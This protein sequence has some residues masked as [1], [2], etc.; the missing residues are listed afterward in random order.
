MTNLNQELAQVRARLKS[1]LWQVLNR[2]PT[3]YIHW[4]KFLINVLIRKEKEIIP[5]DQSFL[6]KFVVELEKEYATLLDYIEQEAKHGDIIELEK[7]VS[8]KVN[9]SFTRTIKDFL[10]EYVQNTEENIN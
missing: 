3:T 7:Y 6:T 10:W 4:R 8:H 5:I 9:G 2:E 1:N